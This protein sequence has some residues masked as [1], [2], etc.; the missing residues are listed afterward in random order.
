LHLPLEAGAHSKPTNQGLQQTPRGSLTQRCKD[1]VVYSPVKWLEPKGGKSGEPGGAERQPNGEN[2][3]TGEK[4]EKKDA[5]KISHRWTQINT[6]DFRAFLS[7]LS[8][9]SWFPPT[10]TAISKGIGQKDYGQKN[11]LVRPVCVRVLFQH[12]FL[13]LIFLASF[14]FGCGRG[15]AEISTFQFFLGRVRALFCCLSARIRVSA[16]ILRAV[17]SLAIPISLDAADG[18]ATWQY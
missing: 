15:R 1:A 14:R 13:P 9:L 18:R 11:E 7:C 16:V 10:T 5:R 4:N 12:I 6:D 8:P 3:E 17:A 2:H